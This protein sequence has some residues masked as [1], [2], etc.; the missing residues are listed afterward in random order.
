MIEFKEVEEQIRT[1]WY[2]SG[3]EM[4][5]FEVHGVIG[6]HVSE[7]S[8]SHRLK[9]VDNMPH[10]YVRPGWQLIEF[11]AKNWSI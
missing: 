2:L 5:P 8:G 7:E 3:N 4:V 1:Y 11:D 9:T 6:V 10:V